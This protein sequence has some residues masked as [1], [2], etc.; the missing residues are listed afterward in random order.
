MASAALKS[1]ARTFRA[2]HQQ[3]GKPLILANVYD[4][5][6]ASI[7]AALPSCHA[8]ATASYA[9][10]RA[11][12]VEDDALTI[13]QNITAA[14]TIGGVA[15]KYGKP[16]TV[17]LQD[18]YGDRLEE[19]VRA[20]IEEAGAVG[21]NLE[22]CGKETHEMFPVD[23]AAERVQ[24]A[25]KVAGDLG[26]QDF[27]VNARCDTLVY[28]GPL[29]DVV[30]R[31]KRYLDAGATTVFVWGGGAR[32]GLHRFEVERLVKEFNGR[33]SVMFGIGQKDG[34]SVPELANLGVARIS[35]GPAI[36]TAIVN[37]CARVAR[38][39]LEPMQ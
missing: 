13:E 29:D 32:R 3:P 17:D 16:L 18:G 2:L 33:L 12:G 37:E 34:L 31:G 36:Q 6:S 5:L 35:V 28:G 10:A 38:E 15:A 25:M 39:I 23:M 20:A 21:I 7:V 24:R 26:L 4:P 27:V 1:L 14:K 8:L 19:A 22:D 9:V 30:T 11:A